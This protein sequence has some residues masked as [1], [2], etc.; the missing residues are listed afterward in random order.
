MEY[1]E[2][3]GTHRDHG[4]KLLAP[5]RTTQNPNPVSESTVQMLQ[6]TQGR[7]HCPG[8]PVPCP[9]PSGADPSLTPSCPSPD[10]APCRSLGPCRCHREPSSALTLRSLG[11]AAAAMR[12]PHSLPCSGLNRLRGLSC[13]LVLLALRVTLYH[14]HSPVT[15]GRTNTS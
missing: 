11:G 3:E 12:P 8:Q 5:H 7:A 6:S 2:L 13:F 4:V 1:P 14:L 15:C 10:T 9:L